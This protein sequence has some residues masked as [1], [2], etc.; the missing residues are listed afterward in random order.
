MHK[1][2]GRFMK[3][4]ILAQTKVFQFLGFTYKPQRGSR[5][6]QWTRQSITNLITLYWPSR[7]SRSTTDTS[8]CWNSI[9]QFLA[10]GSCH[11]LTS[12]LLK[13]LLRNLLFISVTWLFRLDAVPNIDC[14]RLNSSRLHHIRDLVPCN[15]LPLI[16]NV[17]YFK[18]GPVWKSNSDTCLHVAMHFRKPGQRESWRTLVF[19]TYKRTRPH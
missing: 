15:V 2:H 17:K 16:N 6:T 1:Y 4:L 8:G 12:L 5:S 19:L 10:S 3:Y 11:Y 18:I 13:P 14:S 9:Y 7:N